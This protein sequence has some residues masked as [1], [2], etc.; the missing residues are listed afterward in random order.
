MEII[1]QLVAPLLPRETLCCKMD[2]I[3]FKSGARF[4]CTMNW[5]GDRP[6]NSS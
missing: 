2:V 6:V 3:K 4:L 5:V 1:I